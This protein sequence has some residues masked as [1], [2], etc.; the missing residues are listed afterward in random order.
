MS[1]GIIYSFNDKKVCCLPRRGSIL[2]MAFILIF[3]FIMTLGILIVYTVNNEI[4][5]KMVDTKVLNTTYT[6]RSLEALKIMDMG[7]FLVFLSF[8]FGATIGSFFVGSHPIFFWFSIIGLIVVLIIAVF[9]MTAYEEIGETAIM[10]EAAN[11]FTY[12]NLIYNNLMYI[13]TIMAIIIMIALFGKPSST[14]G[15]R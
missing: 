10:Q 8:C 2:D 12:I 1:L 15:G 11:T 9:V 6:G 13:A 4:H 14:F 7:V 5:T 3:L